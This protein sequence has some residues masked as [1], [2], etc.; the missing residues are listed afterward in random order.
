MDN[1]ELEIELLK[2][3]IRE[4]SKNKLEVN[5]LKQEIEFI[6]KNISQIDEK[7]DFLKHKIDKDFTRFLSTK[8]GFY[9]IIASI[10][11]FLLLNKI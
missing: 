11:F 10:L 2:E 4:E 9:A 5:Y 6:K 7:L 3:Y 1:K 8:F